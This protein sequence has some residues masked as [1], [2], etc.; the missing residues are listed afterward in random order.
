MNQNHS[1][2]TSRILGRVKREEFVG[3]NAELERLVA[4]AMRPG[5]IST[6]TEARGLLI[7]MAPLA[8][9]SEL[10]RQT[11]DDLFN[12]GEEIAP[13]YFGLPQTQTTAVSAAIEFLNTF[14]LQYIAFRRDEPSLC[15]ASLTLNDLVQL[16]PAADLDW[17]EELVE[18]YNRQR[19]GDDD[20]ELVRL[21]LSAPRRVP[22]NLARPFVMFDAVQ[23]ANYDDS[24]VAFAVE[25]VRALDASGSPFVLAG[26]RRDILDAIQNAGRSSQ[27]FELLRLERLAEE[28]ARNLVTSAARRGQVS[29]NDETRD[30]LVQQLEGSPFFITSLLHAAREQHL[31]L[32]SYLA[33]ERLYVDELMGGRLH[34]FFSSVL[35]NVAPEP[36]TRAAVVRL[37]CEAAGSRAVSFDSWRKRLRLESVEVE[38]VLRRL[39]IHEL[40]NWD[41]ETIN[42]ESSSNVWKDY[43]KSRFRLDALREPRALVVADVMAAALKRAPQ[44][45]ARHY[46]RAASLRLRE[47][48][49]KFNYQMVPKVL[50]DFADFT[51]AYKGAA[52]EDIV[53]ALDA[54]TDLMRLPQVIHTASGV[55]FS[56]AL[57]QFGEESS[58]VAHAFAGGTYTDE[59]EIV[60]LVAKVE[61]KLEA[62]RAL[63]ERWLGLLEGL[64]RQ[65]GFV[66]TQIWL[67]ANEGF[68]A[69]ATKLLRER[70][71]FGS[72]QQ[73]FELLTARLSDGGAVAA[74]QSDEGNEFVLILPMGADNELLAATTAEQIARRLKFSPEAINQIKH[75]VVE[76]CINASE[77]SLS[78]DRKI[79]QRFRAEDDKLV[80]TIS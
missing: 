13:I 60:W 34:R 27:A 17:I 44:T 37:L 52:T 70:N 74:P 56:R 51:A 80:I 40:I 35:E 1:E 69:E 2:N 65:S 75:A 7:L 22:A 50:F 45:I 42:A 62:A 20:R 67:I 16:A 46:R 31:S 30:L 21:C 49:G 61:S 54:D 48:L 11:F 63:V 18:A 29:L 12:R 36:E 64:A 3:R 25:L 58:V 39:H 28:D 4:H 55:S 47:L 19:F 15:H 79:Y 41:G 76:A 32:D 68:S 6:S 14:L 43:L 78:P 72:S 73:Q 77:H 26:L 53:A 71:A 66:R 8:G 24:P 59:S 23:L 33:C 9:V 5:Q 10:L 57:R 38:Q